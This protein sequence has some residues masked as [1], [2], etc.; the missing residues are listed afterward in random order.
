MSSK[1]YL[2]NDN[3]LLYLIKNHN[4]E[5]LETMFKKYE[6]FIYSK[7]IKYR[8]PINLKEDYLQEGRMVLLKAIETYREEYEKTFMR[9]FELLLQNRFNTLYKNN[10]RYH[11][12]VILVESETVDIKDKETNQ[13]DIIIVDTTS[14]TN[15]EKSIYECYFLENKTVQE[16]TK[17]LNIT[18][19]QVYNSV[20][21][22]KKKIQKLSC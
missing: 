15:M 16:I 1:H 4:E 6:N 3:E 19:K 18:S 2:D 11:S 7:I 12:S 10:K 8:F 21:R 22:I 9:Y 17:M 20:Q 14:L 13:K 5:A